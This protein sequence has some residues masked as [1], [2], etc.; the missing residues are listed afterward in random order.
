[1][2]NKLKRFL[3]KENILNRKNFIFLSI[4]LLFFIVGFFRFYNLGYSD[5]QDSERTTRF[6]L[7]KGETWQEFLLD[8]RKG[9]L[10][11]LITIIPLSITQDP[12]NELALRLPFSISNF[13]SFVVLYLIIY[14]LTKSHLASFLSVGVLSVNGFLVG[15]GRIAQ[16]QSLNILFSFLAILFT[17]HLSQTKSRYKLFSFLAGSC[18]G[19]SFLAHWD[20]IYYSPFLIFFGICFLRRKDLSFIHKTINTLIII[21]SFLLFLLPFL[22]PYVQKLTG[23]N[24]SNLDYLNTR[25]GVSGSEVS[26]HY[27]IFK[28]YNPFITE[29]FYILGLIF[30]FLFFRKTTPFIIWT[31]ISFLAIKFL[32]TTPKTHIYNYLIPLSITSSLGFYYIFV[33]FKNKSQKIFKAISF[34]IGTIIFL[35]YTFLIYQ[36]YVLFIDT[37]PEYPWN[38]KKVLWFKAPE[39]KSDEV[40]TFGFPYF[41]NFDEVREV[42]L[43]D[44]FYQSNESK[45]ITQIYVKSKWGVS[46]KC[47]YYIMIEDPFNLD[48]KGVIYPGLTERKKVFEYTQNGQA[49][50]QVFK[51]K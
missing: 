22:I 14:K 34:L 13:L 26:R 40:I 29:Y 21:A 44:C 50:T 43:E 7:S 42:M 41:R 4:L 31:A 19:I 12:I 20:A 5:F 27:E 47:F 17:V 32:M 9:P 38:S 28:L 35:F 10:Q 51:L 36:S 8:Q 49:Q 45:S 2:K 30:A 46:K 33:F 11:F 24:S 25:M 15:F 23:P 16:Y 39:I 48:G 3:T 1:M 18:Y 6:I 37:Q